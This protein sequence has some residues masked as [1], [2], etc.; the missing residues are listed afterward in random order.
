M[1]NIK[2]RKVSSLALVVVASTL[3]L[4]LSSCGMAGKDAPTSK[5][6]QVTDGVE[7]EIGAVKIRNL[8]FVDQGDA[9]AHLIATIVNQSSQVDAITSITANGATVKT[10]GVA[11][12]EQN[13]P[14]IFGGASQNA[15]GVVGIE[16]KPGQTVSV[17]V[18]LASGGSATLNAMVVEKSGQYANS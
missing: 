1:S 12:L 5:V 8:L 9:T 14:V 16:S 6:R 2:S 17:V 11:A 13:A 4:T 10:T 15:T 18:T 7:G 3:T